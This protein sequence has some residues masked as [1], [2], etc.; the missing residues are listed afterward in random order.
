MANTRS[1]NHRGSGPNVPPYRVVGP[2]GPRNKPGK[3]PKSQNARLGPCG[4]LGLRG[5]GVAARQALLDRQRLVSHVSAAIRDCHKHAETE[6]FTIH[7]SLGDVPTSIHV[8]PNSDG[9]TYMVTWWFW[10]S[11]AG[12]GTLSPPTWTWSNFEFH[13][14]DRTTDQKTALDQLK[15]GWA[16]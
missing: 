2:L 11:L 5:V 8:W 12:S 10:T 3:V 6:P 13:R 7:T 14:S 4:T 16:L 9:T 15:G 1:H